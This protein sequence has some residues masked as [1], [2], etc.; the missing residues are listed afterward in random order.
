MITLGSNNLYVLL[1][2]NEVVFP[3]LQTL[4]LLIIFSR[5]EEGAS[6]AALYSLVG[7]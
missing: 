6:F 5:A 3:K 2:E 4:F 1:E 7:Q